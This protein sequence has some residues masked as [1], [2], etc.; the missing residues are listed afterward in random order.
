MISIEDFDRRRD[1]FHR[2]FDK[3]R[4]QHARRTTIIER[5]IYGMML[6]TGLVLVGFLALLA[7]GG[8]ALLHWLSQT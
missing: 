5:I 2:E 7:L 6:L 8:Y 1:A 3:R 4:Q